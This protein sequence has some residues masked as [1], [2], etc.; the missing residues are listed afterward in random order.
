MSDL[1]TSLER[2]AEAGVS[3]VALRPLREPRAQRRARAR[4]IVA[5]LTGTCIVLAAVGV[6]VSLR[7]TEQRRPHPRREPKLVANASYTVR[8]A[9]MRPTL[10]VGD[11]VSAT[12]H[13]GAIERGDVVLERF[14]RNETNSSV[15]IPIGSETGFERV[16]GI[17]GDIIQGRN[18]HVFVDGR[19]LTE[20]YLK[21]ATSNFPRLVVPPDSY[22]LLGDNRPNSHDSRLRG[23]IP[24]SQITAIALRITAPGARAGP[25]AASPR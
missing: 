13:F 1:K 2:I 10:Q 17:P 24:R 3:G 9:G 18:G 7:S 6:A 23:P 16:V 19:Q 20:P 25:I 8:S 4:T 21:V 22:F 15:N 12:T 14:P 5:A 11:V